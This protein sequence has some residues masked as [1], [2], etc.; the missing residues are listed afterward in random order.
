MLINM[1][2]SRLGWQMQPKDVSCIGDSSWDYF[3]D[4]S[5]YYRSSVSDASHHGW[6]WNDNFVDISLLSPCGC[7]NLY[8]I[9]C[10]FNLMVIGFLWWYFLFGSRVMCSS[11]FVRLAESSRRHG[12]DRDGRMEFLVV[13]INVHL[14][15]V[16]QYI[17]YILTDFKA[18]SCD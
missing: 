7:D 11:W 8:S 13:S 15:E 4:I 2:Y 1:T 12:F 18:S 5:L 9:F 14:S 3:V 6:L 16:I 17:G 10:S